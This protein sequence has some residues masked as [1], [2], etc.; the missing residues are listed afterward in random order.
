VFV[1]FSTP[2]LQI[3]NAQSELVIDYGR[4]L[5]QCLAISGILLSAT[6]AMTGGIQGAG[7][8]QLP[9]L[10]TLASQFGV[11]LCAC[12]ILYL[13][14]ALNIYRIWYMILLAHFV[15]YVLTFFVFR[16]DGWIKTKV[17]LSLN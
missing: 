9:M 12:E 16:T 13:L 8:T 11:L 2:L 6:L 10:I 4:E 15:R 7:A 5:L 3:F 17:E 1:L 14:G